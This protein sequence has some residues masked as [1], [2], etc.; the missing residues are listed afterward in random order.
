MANTDT[1]V[2]EST[3]SYSG[4]G[5][6]EDNSYEQ[7]LRLCVEAGAD[8]AE[9]KDKGYNALQLA[10]IRKGI[11]DKVDVK[12]YMDPSLSWSE[13]E[14]MRLEMY[15]NIDMSMYR[16]QGF[17]TL[18]LAQIRMGLVEEIDVSEYAKKEYFADQMREIRLGLSK[19]GGVPII[20][21]KDPAFDSL[22]MREIRKGLAEGVDISQYAH[23][24]VPYMK[25]R[26]IRESANDG[27]TFS[28]NDI[29][30]YNANILRQ[31]HL[32]F[33]DGVDISK[34][35]KDRFDAEQL[36]EVRIALK[37]GLPIDDYISG[38]MRGDAIKEIRLGIEN[39]VDVSQYADP[40]YGWQQMSEM[41]MGLEHQIDITPYRKPLYQADQMREIR[42]GIEGSLDIGKYSTMMYTAKDMRRIRHKLMA[43]DY[44]HEKSLAGKVE[45]AVNLGKM[46]EIDSF[47]NKMLAYRD[48]YISVEEDNMKCYLSLP[49]REDGKKY[50]EE[51]LLKF[52]DRAK[53]IFGIDKE[54][55][56][57]IASEGR[58]V[59]RYLI[60]EGQ[61]CI[62][63]SDGYYEYFFDTEVNVEPQILHDGTADLSNIELLQ[64][65]KVGDAIAEY[66]RATK[67]TDGYDVYG[68]FVK[69]VPGKEIPI[70]KGT[71]FM[72]M[73]NRTTYAAL[74]SGSIRM[75]DDQIEITKTLVM[76]EV[77]FTD[78]KI[79]YD[80]TLV[81]SGDVSSGSKIEVTG[82]VVV[83][84][85]L[86]NSEIIAG[87]DVIIK[88]GVI[89]PSK[90]GIHTQGNVSAKYFESTNISGKD[91]AANYF[92]NCK[93]ESSG[94][95]KTYGR[96]GIIYGGSINALYGI[97]TANV[98]NK[99]G[100]RTIINLGVNSN[101]LSDFNTI[102]KTINRE[103]EL[104]DSLVKEK[105]RLKEV[106]GGD[107]E[108]IQ[109][110]VKINAGV[111]SKEIRLKEL[112][113]EA[114]SL[115]E[116]INKGYSARAV[117]TEKA[118]AGSIFVISGVVY[119]FEQDRKTYD[120]LTLRVND[121]RDKILIS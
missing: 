96:V 114:Q 2:S 107:R 97:E 100:I 74:Y 45:A 46:T 15:Q 79:T 24:N 51:I 28:K 101:I 38:D 43:G 40:A 119:R 44:D 35:I 84:G 66:H 36:E 37:E 103:E 75:V 105:D 4:L 111:A 18:Q 98:G 86:E 104:L 89:C 34:Y 14:E 33:L 88:G 42:L 82:D 58:P 106:G 81:V 23:T 6:F 67:G 47:V 99:S 116:E 87:G 55:I 21:Y 27:L 49:G 92:I 19:D 32:A 12:K 20:F 16:D 117:I 57:F 70:L 5:S 56:K 30:M 7:E 71:G 91:I 26:V 94:M 22:Q 72:V 76:D 54:A 13:M 85:H 9:L 93:V 25:M 61:E 112:R 50:T 118:Y 63:G 41:R 73:N 3:I 60:A 53:I 29:D 10:E 11:V 1:A 95:V 102:K 52:L 48:A 64:Q 31:M 59:L 17:H 77:K 121:K 80:G 109:W 39:G 113:E 68:N 90:G 120:K 83:G 108:L 8:E 69:S 65:V 115:E 62:N 78:N 110:K